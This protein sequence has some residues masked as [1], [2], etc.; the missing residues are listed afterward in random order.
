MDDMAS[1]V[2]GRHRRGL[3]QFGARRCSVAK[4]GR[5]RGR[6]GGR[7]RGGGGSRE[8]GRFRRFARRCCSAARLEAAVGKRG[9]RHGDAVE[10]GGRQRSHDGEACGARCTGSVERDAPSAVETMR[11]GAAAVP[12]PRLA[13]SGG[14]RGSGAPQKPRLALLREEQR[15]TGRSYAGRR[16]ARPASAVKSRLP[17]RPSALFQSRPCAL[18][19]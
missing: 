3:R 18:L 16:L 1:D 13:S 4:V 7:Q 12:E 2:H 17:L 10:D 19:A 11:A 8:L 6:V 9:Q 14:R 5:Q 15:G